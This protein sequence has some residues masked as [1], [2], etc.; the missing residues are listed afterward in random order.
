MKNRF[1]NLARCSLLIILFFGGQ[2]LF[3]QKTI[4]GVI[5][6]GD[7]KEPLIGGTVTVKGKPGGTISDLNG[8]YTINASSKDVLVFTCIG[9]EKQE[10]PVLDK[11]V[12]NVSL[13]SNS[14]QLTEVVAI[15]Y[16][17][18]VKKTDLTGSIAVVSAK[19]L[20]RNPSASAA[21]ALQGKAP[22]V[23]VFENGSPGGGATI[24]VR[25]VGS[26][27]RGS[28]PIYILD[29]VPVGSIAGILPQEIENI[30]VLKDASA[31]AIYGANGSNGVIII[32]TKRGKSGKTQV[33]LNTYV[34]INLAP[35]QYDMMDADQY[36][37]FYKS[38][39]G[40]KAEYDQAFR[41]KYYGK[42]WQNGTN[43]Q[44]QA[45]KN[46][47]NQ[48]YNLSL[49][50]GGEN[51]N[52]NVAM[53]YVNEDGTVIKTSNER[54]SLRANSDFKLSKHIKF[55]ENAY[56]SYNNG[57]SP[58]TVQSSVYDLNVSPLMK[59]Y[60]SNYV[61]G[62][63][64][65]STPYWID[66]AGN[67]HQGASPNSATYVN[68]LLND[69]P[70]PIA[71]PSLG[72]NRSYG[73]TLRA[74]VYMQVDFNDWLK[75]KVTP[76]AEIG[77]S[78]SKAWLPLFTGNRSPGSASLKEAYSESVYLNLENQLTFNKK[79]NDVHN[80]QAMIVCQV[81]KTT[82]NSISGAASGFDFENLNTLSNGN[83]KTVDGGIS[84]LRMLSYLGRL[85][86]DYKG[87]YFA[88]A[89]FRS[90][91]MSVFGPAFKRGN[92]PALSAAWK[93]NEDFIKQVKEIDM[94]K[95]RFGWG[96]TGNSGGIGS[97]EYYD[98]LTGTNMFSPVFGADQH[99]AN[100]RYAFYQM[101][102][103]LI[104]W[105][106]S[107][108]SNLGADLNMFNSKL[109]A[110]AEYYIK[111]SNNL[112]VKIPIA[113]EMGR[114]A[115]PWV[116]LGDIQNRG[117]ELSLQWRDHIGEFGYGITSNFTT[118]KNQVKNLPVTDITSGNNR[119]IVGHSIGALYGFVSDGIIQLNESNYT[120]GAD[121]NYQ[122]DANGSYIGYK[123]SKQGGKVPQPGDIRFE[124]LNGD[125]D[126][127]DLDKTI[128]GK[129]IPSFNYS[130][131][132]DCTYKNF[133]F[134]IFMYGIADYQIYNQQRASLS[135][136]NSQDMDHNKLNSYAQNHW[137]LENAS[138]T[139]VRVDQANLNINDRISTFWIEDGSFLRI[140]DVQLGYTIPKKSCTRLGVASL[141]MYVNAS[142]L[143]CFTAYKG[144]DPEGFISNNPL[145]GGTDNGGYTMPKSFTFGLQIGF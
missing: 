84:D 37:N 73:S 57:E 8:K 43:W 134:N 66:D 111:S 144:R 67:I 136:M 61:G 25:G 23:L 51:S 87:K 31:T 99:I 89:S 126:V 141:R 40:D 14:T 35:I 15:G 128:I 20:T 100:A 34:G 39:H 115:Q 3:A 125:G 113:P 29:G 83:T 102:S 38:L 112:L 56:M 46:G 101:G 70:N 123:H 10:V 104:H 24:R 140:K 52:F 22:G 103:P 98:Q 142:N 97:W 79:F 96:Q 88:T 119:T 135:S 11:T 131:S 74:S 44:D 28:D 75:Y 90:D 114:P 45:F 59:V 62:F 145:G 92:F 110:S 120:K 54:Y 55:G 32:N 122:K 12:I 133:D 42:G 13:K 85:I 108:M 86:Y 63:E 91:G 107:E 5:T 49:A 50:G 58:M 118:I 132:F 95:L 81:S 130:F 93:V 17:G 27:S 36:S 4:T 7:Q 30:Q 72:S 94:L 77:N 80:V 124:D 137:T 78:R 105:E 129:T 26:I 60:N 65:C 138:N 1:R 53:S 121:G 2:M 139:Y 6:D 33:N 18:T 68:T 106:A 64:S 16:G 21:Q 82:G 117:V 127:T 143:Y 76:S 41:E 116:N 109:Q 19:D 47:Y 48:N 9:M 71:A 69:K